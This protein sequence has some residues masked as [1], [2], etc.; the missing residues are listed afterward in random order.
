M[1][2][3]IRKNVSLMMCKSIIYHFLKNSKSKHQS[4]KSFQVITA[5]RE[6]KK[7]INFFLNVRRNK[8]L[9]L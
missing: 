2:N 6:F 1:N 7:I 4:Q 3:L 5:L 9:V 8:K